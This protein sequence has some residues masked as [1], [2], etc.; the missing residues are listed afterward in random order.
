MEKGGTG[1]H[2]EHVAATAVPHDGHVFEEVG[3]TASG[4]EIR[5]LAGDEDRIA[6]SFEQFRQDS[7]RVEPARIAAADKAG[8]RRPIERRAGPIVGPLAVLHQ[9]DHVKRPAVIGIHERLEV[10][11]LGGAQIVVPSAKERRRLSR[12][13]PPREPRLMP[14]HEQDAEREDA[15]GED[16]GSK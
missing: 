4:Q 16:H 13:Q 15:D 3:I 7:P 1:H 6:A 5:D 2:R 10:L 14:E 11:P 9:V 8:G 12:P